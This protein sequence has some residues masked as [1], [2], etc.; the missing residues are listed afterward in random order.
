M[1]GGVFGAVAI[2]LSLSD[3]APAFL[4]RLRSPLSAL[5]RRFEVA[6]GIDLDVDQS[7]IPWRSDEIVH[8]ALW[9]GGMVLVGLAL[10]HRRQ[11]DRIAV[12]LFASSVVLEVLQAFVTVTRSLS[13]SDAAANGLGI[14]LGLSVVVVADLLLPAKRRTAEVL[15]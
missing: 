10:R 12:G 15:A 5:W 14:M 7:S 3:R 11:A 13:L 4:K 2:V 9:G 6:F 1:I 8:L